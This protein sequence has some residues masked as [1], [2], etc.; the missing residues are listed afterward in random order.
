MS[1]LPQLSYHHLEAGR[2]A[3]WDAL[4]AS[5]GA[6]ALDD[7]GRLAGPYNAFVTAPEVGQH[8]AA[9][10]H[11]L[12][13]E[14]AIDRRLAEL[15]IITV[16]AH[17]RAEYEWW[18]HASIAR[19]RGVSDAVIDAIAAGAPPPFDRGDEASIH[20]FVRALLERRQPDDHSDA[21]ARALLG[22]AGVVELVSLV[23][24]YTLVAFTLVSFDV[25]LPPG[26]APRWR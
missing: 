26:A 25:P 3:V 2:R 6:A 7:S 23:G 5:R 8:L 19:D 20:A 9:V 1:R 11:V 24:Y 22:D 16:A 21:A 15:A 4:V 14:S 17:W 10:G 18:A 13:F 12:R